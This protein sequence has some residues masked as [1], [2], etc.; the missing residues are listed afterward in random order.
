MT[1]NLFSK[2][3]IVLDLGF[4]IKEQKKIAL[5][6]YNCHFLE[7]YGSFTDKNETIKAHFLIKKYIF[8]ICKKFK[9]NIG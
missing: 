5:E 3:L 9:Q 6:L 7:L 4:F 2:I 8:I 1:R